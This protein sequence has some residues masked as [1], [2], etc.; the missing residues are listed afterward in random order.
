MI[1]KSLD[2][3][4][5]GANFLTISGNHAS[6]VFDI[7]GMAKPTVTLANLT[8]A[9]GKTTSTGTSGGALGGGGILNNAG[10]TLNL[11]SCAVVNNQAVAGSAP[12][13]SRLD[14]FGGSLLN[15]GTAYVTACTF[16]GNQALDGASGP[17]L[18]EA[19]AEPSTISGARRLA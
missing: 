6:R 17:S 12:D 19:W 5:P 15:L 3:E 10:A 13:G 1:T 4:G 2:I 7:S 8:I 14:V 9:Y 18:A 16:T 11:T